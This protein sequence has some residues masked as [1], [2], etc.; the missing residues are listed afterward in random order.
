MIVERI[1]TSTIDRKFYILSTITIFFDEL[2]LETIGTTTQLKLKYPSNDYWFS[3]ASFKNCIVIYIK[4][5]DEKF[6]D[7]N[8]RMKNI[9]NL[10]FTFLLMLFDF[11]PYYSFL[12][13]LFIR[14]LQ[15]K[16]V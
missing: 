15:I 16:Q 10:N 3:P 2:T 4:H 12:S 5:V 6:E 9:K 14:E 11:K 13:D 7:I 8:S 1:E